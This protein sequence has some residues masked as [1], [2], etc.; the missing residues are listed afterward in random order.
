MTVAS[1]TECV[2]LAQAAA[3]PGTVTLINFRPEV[4]L[5]KLDHT[6]DSC[7]ADAILTELNNPWTIYTLVLLLI[8]FLLIITPR[9]PS[10]ILSFCFKVMKIYF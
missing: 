9:L 5:C 4:A 7:P 3:P 10:K 2:A 6:D 1:L 8:Y